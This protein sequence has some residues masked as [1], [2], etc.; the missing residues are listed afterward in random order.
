MHRRCEDPVVPDGAVERRRYHRA[1]AMGVFRQS[2]LRALAP[3]SLVLFAIVFLIVVVA[4]LT[5]GGDSS[6]SRSER[7]AITETP[8][9]DRAAERARRERRLAARGVYVVRAGDNLFTIA[10]K[11]GVPIETLRALNPTADPQNLATGQH[12]RLPVKGENGATGAT[13]STGATG[14]TGTTG[15]G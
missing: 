2:S 7:V 4:S 9:R 13:G 10:N 12:I 8:K 5:G 3:A 11:L 15:P 1:R 14:A 6:S